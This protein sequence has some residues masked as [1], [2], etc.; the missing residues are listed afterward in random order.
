MKIVIT[1]HYYIII[2][3][4]LHKRYKNLENDILKFPTL[5]IG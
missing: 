4:I 2:M 5:N 3:R 1:I